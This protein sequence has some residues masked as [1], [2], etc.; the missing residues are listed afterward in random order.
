MEF[1]KFILIYS[2]LTISV[3]GYGLFFSLKLTKYN[4]FDKSN[5]SIGYVGIF[6]IFFFNFYFIFN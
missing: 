2:L 1:I 4:N 3:I 6:G 5:I